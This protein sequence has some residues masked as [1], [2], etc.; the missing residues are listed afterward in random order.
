MGPSKT[1]TVILFIG[2]L[3]FFSFFPLYADE[4]YT[5]EGV[6]VDVTDEN[7]VQARNKAISVAQR[8]ALLILL[9]RLLPPTEVSA[10]QYVSEERLDGLVQDFQIQ[11]EKHS[12]VRY[13]ATFKI[14]FRPAVVDQFISS[15]PPLPPRE[16]K[17]TEGERGALVP[18]EK[19]PSSRPAA[20]LL[21]PLF[22]R[23]GKIELWEEGN[24][25]LQVWNEED[26]ETAQL[27][28]PVG[29]LQDREVLPVRDGLQFEGA[30][31]S[32]ILNRYQTNQ[33]LVVKLKEGTPATLEV[34]LIG[35]AGLMGM[36]D[37]IVLEGL[38]TFDAAGFKRAVS[39]VLSLKSEIMQGSKGISGMHATEVLISFRSHKEWLSWQQDLKIFPTVRKVD[40]TA[41]SRTGA[42][43][44][45]HHAGSL[46]QLE[47]ILA[48]ENFF[49]APSKED[50]IKALQ[51]G[52]SKASASFAPSV[53]LVVSDMDGG[54]E[55]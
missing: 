24:P 11:N 19:M 33:A 26:L 45:L 14:R 49:L 1:R 18:Q 10:Y 51:R 41:L 29:D 20:P 16:E 32:K 38:E 5:V 48:R 17:G 13:L 27:V 8:Q 53:P 6:S 54:E 4:T 30:V 52:T 31:F 42:R 50:S 40:V 9:E 37:R 12:N 34:Y 47:K 22:E 15:P 23:G 46:E 43:V 2:T 36:S 7:P 39:K 3:L 28:L 55:E 21:I 25:W 44:V 35:R